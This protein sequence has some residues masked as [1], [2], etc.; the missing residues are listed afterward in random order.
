M[1]IPKTIKFGG[2]VFPVD[3]S[4]LELRNDEGSLLWGQWQPV[5]GKIVLLSKKAIDPTRQAEVFLHEIIHM[6]NTQFDF[7]LNE[8]TVRALSFGLFSVLVQ[9]KLRFY[10]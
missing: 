7:S 6:I 4:L 8:D 5:S 3:S 9:N 1:I 10:E 2:H